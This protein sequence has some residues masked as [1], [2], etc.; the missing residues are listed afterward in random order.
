MTVGEKIKELRLSRN[1]TQEELA[2]ICDFADPTSICWIEKGKRKVSLAT[3]NKICNYFGVTPNYFTGQVETPVDITKLRAIGFTD[4]NLA[5]LN[6][7]DFAR[8]EAYL[9]S[10]LDSKTSK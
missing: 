10:L 8:L 5:K 3:L 4:E 7:Q 6:Q 2:R 9:Q 1:V